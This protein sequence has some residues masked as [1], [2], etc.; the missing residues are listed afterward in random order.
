[1][2]LAKYVVAL[3]ALAAVLLVRVASAEDRTLPGVAVA[4]VQ[5]CLSAGHR[6]D[7][8]AFQVSLSEPG[9]HCLAVGGRD[10]KVKVNP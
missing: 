3:L 1:M 4:D 10:I 2:L 9:D 5:S 8:V 6:T 7:E